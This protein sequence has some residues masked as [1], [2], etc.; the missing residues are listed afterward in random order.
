MRVVPSIDISEG[1][2]VKRIRGVRG[3]GLILGDPVR[4][5]E[6][7]YE[8]GYDYIHVVDLDAAEGIGSNEDVIRR[9]ASIGFKKVQVGGGI[10]SLERALR[11]LRMG[12]TDI[13][14]STIVFKDDF[15]FRRMASEIGDRLF[16]SIDYRDG[17]ALISGWRER[18]LPLENAISRALAYDIEGIIFTY[19]S[20]EGTGRGVDLS[21]GR[22]LDRIKGVKGYAGGVG[23]IDDLYALKR[24]GFDFV[25]VGRAFYEGVIRGV[26]QV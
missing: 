6:G 12:V 16:V 14:V 17:Y 3:T 25:I 4:I 24:L 7:I 22:Y 8:E 15:E 19:V 5:A 13:V 1:K 11:L 20:N 26:K 10:R 18:A 23:S 9:I 2:A 21:I